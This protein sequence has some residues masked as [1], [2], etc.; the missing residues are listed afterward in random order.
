MSGGVDVF[1]FIS[2]FL[3]TGSLLRSGDK[4]ERNFLSSRYARTFSRLVP[5]A[6][7]SLAAV[8][9]GTIWFLPKSEW[10]GSFTEIIAS[11]LYFEN[12]Q[13][14]ESR[15]SYGAA[16][17]GASA[18]QHF[19]SL[20]IQGQFFILWPIVVLACYTLARLLSGK[21]GLRQFTGRRVVL[22]V[23]LL[24]TAASF[25]FAI[26]LVR[27]DQP[28]A[29]FHSLTR[30]WQLGLGALVAIVLSR[31]RVPDSVRSPI[32][33]LGVGIIMFSGFFVD[34]LNLF[35]G[36]WSLVPLSGVVLVLVGSG[37][38]SRFSVA[39]ILNMRPV[40][41][42]ADI[43]YGLYLWHWPILVFYLNYRGWASVG[44]KGALGILAVS[45]V[46]A[47]L[48]KKLFDVLVP[49]LQARGRWQT[50][51]AIITATAVLVTAT[52]YGAH[53][54]NRNQQ[55]MLDQLSS[56]SPE[57]PGAAALHDPQN[58]FGEELEPIPSLDILAKD[59]PEIYERKCIQSYRKTPEYGEV[60]ICD[61]L[62]ADGDEKLRVVMSGG[63]HVAQWYPAMREVAT[64]ENWELLLVDKDGCRLRENDPDAD[65]ED[66]CSIWNESAV[67]VIIALEPDIVFTV[68]TRTKPNSDEETVANAQ[69]HTWNELAEAGISV[70]AIRDNPRWEYRIPECMEEHDGDWRKC[71]KARDAAF[72]D[73]SPM[74]L[75]ED[76][77]SNLVSIDLSDSICDADRCEAVVGNVI[78]YRDHGHLGATYVR[79]MAPALRTALLDAAPWMFR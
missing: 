9:V 57:Y 64:A 6:I 19:W 20:S 46:I 31:V 68:A 33:W 43:S 52:G 51:T 30:F 28:I 1:L 24:I 26:Y 8:A 34:G 50:L 44:W 4:K 32:A 36:P 45:V 7:L 70:V 10:Y 35:P 72:P 53:I 27:V 17:A 38:T 37:S 5:P 61:D 23:T 3:L 75:R 11:A 18:L 63:S 66:A 2:A 48:S 39:K 74:D 67:E 71:G 58:A 40:K 14:I 42:T 47:A 60:K 73:V 77:P 78:V 56:I 79:T 16:G 25:L 54:I 76:L 22:A 69:V 59:L 13:L 12:F 15:L 49:K 55:Q 62:L 41:F 29:Y 65:M 21:L